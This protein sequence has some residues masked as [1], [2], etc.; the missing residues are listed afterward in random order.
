MDILITQDY[1][2]M[3]KVAAGLVSRQLQKK[4]STVLGLPTGSTPIGLYKQLRKLHRQG[5]DFSR[6]STF[7]LDEY[8]GI[9]PDHPQ[10][11]RRFMDEHLFDHVNL[12]PEHIH[13]PQ[14]DTDDP[15]VAC[16]QYDQALVASGGIDLMVVG[17][18]VNGHI[19]FNEPAEHLFYGTSVVDLTSE[20]IQVNADKFFDGDIEQVPKQAISM[21][22]A[23]IMKSRR[24]ILLASGPSKH[25]AVMAAMTKGITTRNPMSILCTHPQLTVVL[26]MEVWGE[27]IPHLPPGTRVTRIG[28]DAR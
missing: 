9:G 16:H 22:M 7:N 23:S 11:Y 18:G 8:L 4:P 24:V 2:H 28:A 20:T 1:Q 21:G 3:S 5:L 10:S 14:G 27:G 19:G 17:V 13:I 25:E 6:V 26:D 15:Q 12:A